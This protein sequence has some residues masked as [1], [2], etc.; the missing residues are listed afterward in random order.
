MALY[1]RRVTSS[2]TQISVLGPN[3]WGNEAATGTYDAGTFT[4]TPARDSQ[5]RVNQASWNIVPT[6]NWVRV[7]GTEVDNILSMIRAAYGDPTFKCP[8]TEVMMKATCDNYNGLIPDQINQ[9]LWFMNAGGHVGGSDN[10][11][12]RFDC[13]KMAWS[14]EKLPS[15]YRTAWSTAYKLA[16]TTAG[17]YTYC[18]ESAAQ[19]IN[20]RDSSN[21]APL[22]VY[23]GG[24][25]GVSVPT[26]P[27]QGNCWYYDELYWDRAPTARHTYST[28]A[29]DPVRNQLISS[30]RRRIWTFDLTS[31]QYTMRRLFY[32]ETNPD[33][34]GAYGFLDETTGEYLHGGAADSRLKS[35]AYNF[36]TNQ[37]TSWDRVGGGCP[38][39]AY[40]VADSRHERNV[41]VISSIFSDG[42]TQAG[43]YWQYNL[44]SRTVTTPSSSG[45][46][47]QFE[48]PLS[49]ASFLTAEGSGYADGAALCYVPPI[50]RYWYWM[51]NSL[52]MTPFELDPTTSP[53]TLRRKTFTGAVPSPGSNLMR[54]VLWMPGLNAVVMVDMSS[55]PLYVYKF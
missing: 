40:N 31:K 52:G 49:Q 51:L 4:W 5:G 46:Q 18:D 32:D 42:G 12:Y 3:T 20:R 27:S 29:F 10:G 43:K 15:D 50:N 21:P 26:L 24:T 17:S 45:V 44:D 11:I 53:W 34:D 22:V 6:G 35:M 1:P 23:D 36:S 28:Q 14:I 33:Y 55:I 41:T 19:Y 30:T 54:K 13:Y 37:W 9:R 39:I 8:G 16:Q 2:A 38:W 7:A 48:P 47:V 25:S